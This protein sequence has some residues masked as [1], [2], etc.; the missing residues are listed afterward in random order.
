[1]VELGKRARGHFLTLVKRGVYLMSIMISR[2]HFFLL[3]VLTRRARVTK[4]RKRDCSKTK[5]F[6]FVACVAWWFFVG[7]GARAAKPRN[8]RAKRARTS[9][10]AARKISV[11]PAP[12]SSRFFCPRP[13]LLLSN[14]NRHATQAIKFVKRKTHPATILHRK[15]CNV[16][17]Y[18]PDNLATW[19][20]SLI[21][22]LVKMGT[23]LHE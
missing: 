4:R 1:M 10:E 15:L 22:A 14:Q 21:H 17:M 23:T 13:P 9:G 20:A 18:L 2:G 12:I 3:P 11:A 16:Y 7:P 8:S 6:K 19:L 5:P